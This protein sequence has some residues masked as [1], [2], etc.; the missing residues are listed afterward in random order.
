LVW[1]Q[2]LCGRKVQIDTYLRADEKNIYTPNGDISGIA[3]YP[4]NSNEFMEDRDYL[5]AQPIEKKMKEIFTFFEI[6]DSE[7]TVLL[8]LD[9][10][11]KA[12]IE[13]KAEDRFCLIIDKYL[14]D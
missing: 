2:D 12:Q 5:L 7:G 1:I 4:V 8:N 6:R 3:F 11:E 14:Y 10:L 13:E 9:T